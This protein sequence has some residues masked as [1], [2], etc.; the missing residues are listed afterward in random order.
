MRSEPWRDAAQ[1]FETSETECDLDFEFAFVFALAFAQPSESQ[2]VA[3]RLKRLKRLEQW[4]AK[5]APTYYE[6]EAVDSSLPQRC[7]HHH[8]GMNRWVEGRSGSACH[9]QPA[10]ECLSAQPH[11]Q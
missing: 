6:A 7:H 3:E 4:E 10:M 1:R 5:R 9:Y 2:S 8:S 11:S